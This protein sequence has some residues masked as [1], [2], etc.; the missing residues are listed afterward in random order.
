[1]SEW[2]RAQYHTAPLHPEVKTLRCMVDGDFRRPA[3]IDME[4]RSRL[5]IDFDLLGE[6]QRWLSYRVVHC[7][8]DWMPSD[9]SELD[10]IEGF[11]PNRLDDVRP[12]FN[13]FI[14]YYHYSLSFPNDQVRLLLSGNYAVEFFEDDAPDEVIAVATFSISEGGVFIA[15][16][17]S[18][19]TDVDYR[20][21]H[22]Q[23]SCSVSWNLDR[24]P[25]LDPASDLRLI[26][27]QDRDI[28]T[29]RSIERPSRLSAQSAH[30]EHISPLIFLAGNHYRR[31][32]FTDERYVSIGVD[33]LTYEPPYYIT[34][35]C[36]D[37]VRAGASYLYD[38]DQ[39]GRFL[40]HA[41]RVEDVDTEA[42]Y[43]KARFTLQTPMRWQNAAVYVDGDM[44]Y[45][46]YDVGN[47]LHYDEE[48]MS[49]RGEMLLKQGAYN[50]RYVVGD[51]SDPT[52]LTASPIEGDHYE[53]PAEYDVRVYYRPPGARY[54]RL[55]G[56]AVITPN[57][58]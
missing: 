23:L 21:R 37:R 39:R 26:V 16:E 58:R 56:S 50:Y 15:A 43:F 52:S 46:L 55:V 17:V 40:V 22:Q 49:Y 53:T 11:Q 6:Q 24:M 30:Y 36:S 44:T 3:I 9:I 1:M 45:D 34:W 2:V 54:D 14:A 18:A 38:Q 51:P 47:E 25:H 20:Q 29:R 41:L 19:N 28:L 57:G 35:L 10:Y 8:A 7:D 48:T 12:S 27:E 31:F 42:D 13:T 33:Q 5:R 4:G 32:E